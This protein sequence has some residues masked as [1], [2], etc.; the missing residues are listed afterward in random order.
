MPTNLGLN[1][2]CVFAGE[3]TGDEM[4]TFGA[5]KAARRF[6]I[7]GQSHEDICPRAGSVDGELT[8]DRMGLAGELIRDGD[9]GYAAVCSAARFFLKAR[10]LGVVG[11]IGP[12]LHRTQ[13]EFKA[14]TLRREHLT[15]IIDFGAGQPIGIERWHE[16]QCF[17]A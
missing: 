15:V 16:L 3:C 14:E 8:F 10:D 6:A 4:N 17:V 5:D 7:F 12:F 9:A 13:N 1:S 2:E 11:G